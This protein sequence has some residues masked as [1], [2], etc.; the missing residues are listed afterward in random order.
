MRSIQP[1]RFSFGS[2]VFWPALKPFHLTRYTCSNVS[3]S[4]CESRIAST[5]NSASVMVL[6][7]LIGLEAPDAAGYPRF[8][9]ACYARY[10][11]QAATG[12]CRGQKLTAAEVTD[13][14]GLGR[15]AISWT[16]ADTRE[17]LGK[18]LDGALRATDP[19]GRPGPVG[20]GVITGLLFVLT[21]SRDA[22]PGWL[23]RSA[24][25][26]SSPFLAS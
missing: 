7:F 4:I 17:P 14:A 22:R 16:L 20:L 21:G 24:C 8:L 11:L 26:S 10:P 9:L 23:S 1:P 19:R 13:L 25:G 18:I 5:S 15:V 2:Q 6:R 12:S 3:A